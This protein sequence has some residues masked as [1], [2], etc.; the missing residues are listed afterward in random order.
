MSLPVNTLL[1]LRVKAEKCTLLVASISALVRTGVNHNQLFW[2]F[3][4]TVTD[5]DLAHDT[6]LSAA[7]IH[8]IMLILIEMVSQ[9]I[10]LLAWHDVP[11]PTIQLC[12]MGTRQQSV[13]AVML[14]YSPYKNSN[15]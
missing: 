9:E 10:I 7:S 14:L 13:E 11:R 8:E 12:G 5:L 1:L 3:P 2:A 4:C 6:N 15:H